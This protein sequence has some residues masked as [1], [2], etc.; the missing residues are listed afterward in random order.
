MTPAF[1]AP[2]LQQALRVPGLLAFPLTDFDRSGAFVPHRF[3]DRVQWLQG[4]GAAA[5]VIAGGAGEYFSLEPDE[6]SRVLATA[7]EARL[8][9]VPFLA[10][11]GGGTRSAVAAARAA[12]A[13]GADGILLL[14]PYL[15]E[16]SQAGLEAHVSAVCAATGLGVMVYGRAN[17]RPAAQTL[18]RLCERH[19]NLIGYKDGLGDLESLWA[20][21]TLLGD[22]LLVLNGMPT[23]EVY[24]PAYRG[25][26][27]PSYSSAVFNFVPTFARAFFDAVAREDS[28]AVHAMMNDFFVPFGRIRARQPGYAVSIL[29]AGAT[30]VGRDAGPVRPPLS[31]LTAEERQQLAVL[32]ETVQA[33]ERQAAAA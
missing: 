9:P 8:Q 4:F 6:A 2:A 13:A 11:A 20:I 24:A 29:K 26:G 14:P 31:D 7:L 19:P 32:I 22:R 18:A 17:C 1:S 25:M 30:I 33:A 15:T 12:E 10:S 21:R 27:I 28:A 3:A 5:F 23:A 16:A